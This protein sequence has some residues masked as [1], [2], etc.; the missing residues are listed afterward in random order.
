[1]DSTR[2]SGA[3]IE[4]DQVALTGRLKIFSEIL[5]SVVSTVPS[6]EA[7]TGHCARFELSR[8]Q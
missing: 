4:G 5:G 3:P 6:F 7:V 2:E 1:M 8:V